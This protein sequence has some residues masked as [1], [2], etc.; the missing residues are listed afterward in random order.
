M[1][2]ESAASNSQKPAIIIA[3]RIEYFY[4]TNHGT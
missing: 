4:L 1:H 2:V 3:V